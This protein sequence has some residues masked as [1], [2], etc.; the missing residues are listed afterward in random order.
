MKQE[1]RFLDVIERDFESRKKKSIKLGIVSIICFLVGIMIV[2]WCLKNTAMD[3]KSLLLI[4]MI[5]VLIAWGP[6]VF[7]IPHILAY[8]RR[9][10][11]RND[12]NEITK[13]ISFNE[14]INVRKLKLKNHI[15]ENFESNMMY[16]LLLELL[17]D[18]DMKMIITQGEESDRQVKVTYILSNG[19]TVTET[20]IC[21]Q[22]DNVIDLMRILSI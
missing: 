12:W 21:F 22:N 5:G 1:I 17:P 15:S 10:Q 13:K 11:N 6:M 16:E 20:F 2:L 4:M 9:R 14:E 3:L 7:S 18:G 8:I 19:L